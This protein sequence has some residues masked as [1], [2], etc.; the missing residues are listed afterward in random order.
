M[1]KDNE[2]FFYDKISNFFFIII[3]HI[4]LYHLLKA[5]DYPLYYSKQFKEFKIRI[6]IIAQIYKKTDFTDQSEID[7]EVSG[8]A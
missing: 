8:G 1:K 6:A 7:F 2:R 3:I 5:L 4:A